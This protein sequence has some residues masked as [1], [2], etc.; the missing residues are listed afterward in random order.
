MGYTNFYAYD[1]NASAYIKAWP[2]MGQD[3]QTIV[4]RVQ[5]LG[6]AIGPGVPD[7]QGHTE[8]ECNERWIWLNGVGEGVHDTLLIY[9]PGREALEAIEDAE[10]WFGRADFLRAFC[11]TARMPYDTAVAAIL[12]RCHELAPEAFVI[13][14]DG[15]WDRE[16]RNGAW[17]GM[18][19]P[20][21]LCHELFDTPIDL[22]DP[23]CEGTTAGPPSAH[24]EPSQTSSGPC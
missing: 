21:A 9:G 20:R 18:V 7:Y 19:S 8:P 12:L 13:A 22:P 6:I 2:Q 3:A 17:R 14:S 11:K 24:K 15:N 1:P 5:E 10:R 4:E 23:L 16:W